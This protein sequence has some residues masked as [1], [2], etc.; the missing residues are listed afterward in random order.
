MTLLELYGC[1]SYEELHEKVEKKSPEVQE[2]TDFMEHMGKARV[3]NR[4]NIESLGNML[5]YLKIAELDKEKNHLILFDTSNKILSIK[6]LEAED[7][8]KEAFIAG[9]EGGKTRGVML[10]NKEGTP[11]Y[12]A[13]DRKVDLEDVLTLGGMKVLDVLTPESVN[14]VD[15]YSSVLAK[16]FRAFD[17]DFRGIKDNKSELLDYYSK[18]GSNVETVK[19]NTIYQMISEN[20][21]TRESFQKLI[22]KNIESQSYNPENIN[23]LVDTL[24]IGM[25]SHNKEVFKL[26]MMN[27][28]NE[29]ISSKDMF[30]GTV[31][32]SA[33]YPYEIMKEVHQNPEVKSVLFAHNHPSGN[34]KPSESDRE[35]TRELRKGLDVL[36]IKTMDHL[37][38]SRNGVVSLADE[39]KVHF[40][41]YVEKT[42]ETEVDP[43]LKEEERFKNQ[44]SEVQNLLKV[45]HSAH[46]QKPRFHG[47]TDPKLGDSGVVQTQNG[48]AKY[49]ILGDEEKGTMMLAVPW[50]T[51]IEIVGKYERFSSVVVNYEVNHEDD[52]RRTV[53]KSIIIDKDYDEF[54]GEKYKLDITGEVGDI[55]DKN[56]DKTSE[57]I[58]IEKTLDTSKEVIEILREQNIPQ[59]VIKEFGAFAVET[60]L[61]TETIRGKAETNK[62]MNELTLEASV[63][64][65][66]YKEAKIENLGV[67]PF[68]GENAYR[69]ILDDN[70]EKSIGLY[71]SQS[72]SRVLNEHYF[73]DNTV[74]AFQKFHS[75]VSKKISEKEVANKIEKE[76]E[77]KNFYVE[78]H[79]MGFLHREINV[80]KTSEN[81]KDTYEINIKSSDDVNVGGTFK[82]ANN[83]KETLELLRDYGIGKEGMERFKEI[84]KLELGKEDFLKAP[85]ENKALSE[86]ERLENQSREIEKMFKNN[87]ERVKRDYDAVSLPERSIFRS[88][89]LERFLTNPKDGDVGATNFK[90]N[91]YGYTIN[92]DVEGKLELNGTWK[93]EKTMDKTHKDW[94][95]KE[96]KEKEFKAYDGNGGLGDIRIVKGGQRDP[97]RY[98]VNYPNYGN[99]FR[100]PEKVSEFLEN[101]LT[102]KEI[103]THFKEDF[104]KELEEFKEL[105]KLNNEKNEK[106]EK[107]VEVKIKSEMKSG[108]ESLKISLLKDGTMI[109]D[110]TIERV[111]IQGNSEYRFNENSSEIF[112]E[113]KGRTYQNDQIETLLQKN[114]FP[115]S[116]VNSF[117]EFTLEASKTKVKSIREI[118]SEKNIESKEKDKNER[119]QGSL[120]GETNK[121]KSLEKE[122]TSENIAPQENENKHFHT[123]FQSGISTKEIEVLK[124]EQDG[125]SNYDVSIVAYGNWEVEK[126]DT[127]KEVIE[128]LKSYD[129]PESEI[130]RFENEFKSEIEK[131]EK[132]PSVSKDV[133][134]LEES[135]EKTVEKD[136]EPE[137]IKTFDTLSWVTSEDNPEEL[138]VNK[139]LRDGKEQ[140]EV[141]TEVMGGFDSEIVDTP[142]EVVKLLEQYEVEK[143][144]IKRFGVEFM[145]EVDVEIPEKER[146]EKQ[147]LEVQKTLNL[148]LSRDPNFLRNTESLS[149]PKLG[150]AGI[151][152]LKD[153]IAKYEILGKEDGKKGMQLAIPL[154]ITKEV[155]KNYQSFNAKLQAY[156]EK[157]IPKKD[158]LK[159]GFF[160]KDELTSMVITRSME[161]GKENY[162]VD[163]AGRV[164]LVK[165]VESSKEVI[166]ILKEKEL[167]K[168][169]IEEFSKFSAEKFITEEQRLENQSKEILN[170][171]K[172][173]VEPI[174]VIFEPD[175]VG[176]ALSN[177]R[178]R[179]T[180]VIEHNGSE[181]KYR[182]ADISKAQDKPH[183]VFDWKQEKTLENENGKIFKAYHNQAGH[184]KDISVNKTTE[185]GI[186]KYSVEIK[187][188]LFPI[189]D[190]SKEVENPKEVIELLQGNGVYNDIV[191]NFKKDFSPE[192]DKFT[193]DEIARLEKKNTPTKEENPKKSEKEKDDKY[194]K[195]DAFVEHVIASLEKGKIPW[196]K[197]WSTS[198]APYNSVTEKPYTGKNNLILN[199]MGDDKGYTDPRWMTYNQAKEKGWQVNK[200]EKSVPLKYV[201]QVDKTT[202]KPVDKEMLK[203]L[204][205]Q[206][207]MDYQRNLRTV[208]KDFN[209]FNAQQI[210]GIPPLEKT[211]R[212]VDFSKIDKILENSNI[213]ISY[214]GDRAVYNSGKDTIAL[215]EKSQFKSENGFYATALHELAHS[216][217]HPLRENRDMSGKFGSSSYAKEELRAELASVFIGQEKGLSYSERHLENST[218]YLKGWISVLKNDPNELHKAA[219][220]ALKI[221]KTVLGYENQKQ[222]TLEVLK[223]R[224]KTQ[225]IER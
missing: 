106:L 137:V 119:V 206:D 198:Q 29:I 101:N 147:S 134:N 199:V 33:V 216:T 30:T 163:V 127:S 32:R 8:R 34:V 94:Y 80:R 180:G 149:N 70:G 183:V 64:V 132:N 77:D 192:I 88:E 84:F 177:P 214:R 209:V 208:I 154:R 62:E 124:S 93:K 46:Y 220:D 31:D 109:K 164:N 195:P 26:I 38:I 190:Q 85:K 225:G 141:I 173:E 18:D 99:G 78:I 131:E 90:G 211:V 152:E 108:M 50:R 133:E 200:G 210:S 188:V 44:R 181:Y 104:R 20:E 207:R 118:D 39:G 58:D 176:K 43:K 67:E 175:L 224:S 3:D 140:Y 45:S 153:G 185:N 89:N 102:N 120:F 126:V 151:V 222:P 218:E 22:Q 117:E 10:I 178:D 74:E 71:N 186:D 116:A 179:D 166:N 23:K 157:E 87:E 121:A 172:G 54:G 110:V 145:A 53:N 114:G 219:S 5:D 223:N 148:T 72:L 55:R 162:H 150:D 165:E 155:G 27:E 196:E 135:L 144:E 107:E 73:P 170:M 19:D 79:G 156:K 184:K 52:F 128:I 11:D 105:E 69:M 1:N 12:K 197:D 14:G 205:P 13:A 21:E 159:L 98:Y 36:G 215:P 174:K 182:V 9:L 91:S 57:K 113:N 86:N 111:G 96:Y 65:G 25:G 168:E 59:E 61:D 100:N 160:E 40:D 28:Y 2:L 122:E 123:E 115:N 142:Q 66:F 143:D 75:E 51:D 169:V 63:G 49:Q 189:H 81:G 24:R 95:G 60:A 112:N 68:S 16:E 193:K 125:K 48:N 17:N 203:K 212:E 82:E 136:E 191:K 202:G 76:V 15:G 221:S 138:Q 204:S 41:K 37:I 201:Y 35:L 130:Q 213:E 167:P 7:I 103:L 129:T 171:I 158:G 92:K 217:G 146:L 161:N 97:E 56:Y 4:R 6:E 42:R 47:I 194:T 139:L 187:N 83:S